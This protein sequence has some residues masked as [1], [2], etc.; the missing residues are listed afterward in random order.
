M[1]NKQRHKSCKLVPFSVIVAASGGNVDAIN[2]VLN[3]Y[4]GYI[5]TLAMR[6]LYDEHGQPRMCV[7]EALRRRLETKLIAKVLI[8]RVA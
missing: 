7:D 5:S 6:R 4:G 3:H 8:F 2:I 1:M